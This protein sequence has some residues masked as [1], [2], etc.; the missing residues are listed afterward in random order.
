MVMMGSHGHLM[1]NGPVEWIGF[2][3]A[4]RICFI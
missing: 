3:H 4:M 2:K 1:K